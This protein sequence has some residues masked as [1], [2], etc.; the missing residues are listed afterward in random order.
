MMLIKKQLVVLLAACII[1]VFALPADALGKD[2]HG[3]HKPHEDDLAEEEHLVDGEHNPDYDHEAFLG[4]RKDEFD[5]LSPEEAKK[6]LKLL[7]AT[8]DSDGDKHVTQEELKKWVKSVFQ[9]KM[10][11]GMETDV[12]DKDKNND[13]VI[14]WEEFMNDSYGEDASADEDEEMKKMIE[15]DRKHFNVADSSKDGKLNAE[16][17]AG[18]LHPETNPEMQAL[19]AEETLEGKNKGSV[20]LWNLRAKPE[21]ICCYKQPIKSIGTAFNNDFLKF[22]SINARFQVICQV[23][24]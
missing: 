9:K 10:L 5:H 7:I 1:S 14:S 3:R 2:E 13:G 11:S 17:F 23:I 6:R 18:F 4:D 15:R 16:E 8:V 12:K 19:N 22:L 24:M 21:R 20:A